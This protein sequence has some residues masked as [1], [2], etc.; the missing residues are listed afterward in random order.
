MRKNFLIVL[1][2]VS[3]LIGGC[4]T[5]PKKLDQQQVVN[6]EKI[7]IITVKPENDLVVLDHTGVWEKTYTGGQFGALGGLLEGIVLATEAKIAKNKSLGGDPDPL[8]AELGHVPVEDML[9]KSLFEKLSKKYEIVGPGALCTNP[10]D[11]GKI[12]QSQ[13]NTKTNDNLASCRQL[14]VD[15]LI[16]TEFSY[17]LAAYKGE[18]A[19][20]AIDADITVYS[21]NEEKEVA[22]LRISSDERFKAGHVI[23]EY[24]AN[25]CSI[26]R[27]DIQKAAEALASLIAEKSGLI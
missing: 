7:A 10:E 1:L 21:V 17:G 5:V 19:S 13:F 27:E 16:I 2:V 22:K 15:T 11:V 9:T 14:M 3:F 18:N 4:T 12:P 26:F 25:E 24:R 8:R 20:A 23:E 6:I